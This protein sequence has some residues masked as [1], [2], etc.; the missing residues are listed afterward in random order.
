MCSIETVR[1]S[2]F[3]TY[4]EKVSLKIIDKRLKHL[5]KELRSLTKRKIPYATNNLLTEQQTNESQMQHNKR[6]NQ[7]LRLH[8]KQ[9]FD[10]F[11][12]NRKII[13]DYFR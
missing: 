7:L 3:S 4:N 2:S 10:I 1:S 5:R 9:V 6:L 11:L 12:I 8:D 13:F